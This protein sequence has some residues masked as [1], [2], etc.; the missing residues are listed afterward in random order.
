MAR[1][2]R[3]SPSP[4]TLIVR[5]HAGEEEGLGLGDHLLHRDPD[6]VGDPGGLDTHIEARTGTLRILLGP[7]S[8][9]DPGGGL[10]G[11]GQPLGG[12][13]QEARGQDVE[14]LRRADRP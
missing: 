1:A 8:L 9:E 4:V 5:R 2:Q 14:A 6:L 13:G 7:S 12:R 11:V 10:P 3:A